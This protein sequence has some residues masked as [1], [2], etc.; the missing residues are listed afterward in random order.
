MADADPQPMLT[1]GAVAQRLGISVSTLRNWDRRYGLGPA[2]HE[3]GKHRRYSG[4]D[5]QCVRQMVSLTAEGVPPASAAAVAV[6]AASSPPPARDGGGSGAVAVGRADRAVRGLGR[7]ATRL[8]ISGVASLVDQHIAESGVVSTWERLLVPLLRSLGD[9]F[10]RGANV[11][12]IEHAASAGILDALH[13]VPVPEQQQ[14]LPALLACA[15][16]EQHGL[17]L[18]ALAAG[19]AEHSC[20]ARFLGTRVSEQALGTAVNKLKPTCLVLWTHSPRLARRVPLAQLTERC[21]ALLVAGPGWKS[22]RAA[23]DFRRPPSLGEA[24]E[25]V[26]AVVPSSVHHVVAQ[27]S[28]DGGLLR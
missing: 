18:E 28:S 4:H 24:L 23:D 14:R 26:L 7:A 25:M 17:P 11:V 9:Q 8:D 12:A 10:E 5:F 19:L 27:R 20:P 3:P 16:E 6:G 2:E 1:A 15:P 22:V 21:S 13:R